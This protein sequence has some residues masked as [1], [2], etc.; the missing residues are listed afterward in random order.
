MAFAKTGLG[1]IYY[2]V[3]GEGTPVVLIRGLGCWSDHWG[4]WEQSLTE[5]YRVITLDGRGLGRS[6]VPIFPWDS[7]ST[8]AGDVLAVL[9]TEQ[10]PSAHI[11]GVSLGGMIA[12]QFGM[13]HPDRTKSITPIN[14][15]V[16]GSGHL[17]LTVS[18]FRLISS[19]HKKRSEFFDELSKLL[20]SPKSSKESLLK[21]SRDWRA[22]EER[23]P[24]PVRAVTCQL[25]LSLRWRPWQKFSNMNV[26]VHI[27]YGEDDRFVPKG[28]SLFIA[29]K[30]PQA[31]VTAMADSGHEP[32]IDQPEALTITLV[33][34][35]ESIG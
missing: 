33:R 32:H 22:I 1:N 12:L 23:Y 31:K 6:T 14:S 3:E 7:M 4:G 30:T 29:E 28:N 18:A 26:P 8:L 15:S 5:K 11:V 19:G 10:I 17:R 20:I 9:D 34:Y 35:F 2:Q 21:I 24:P 16:G 27:I 25:L 13:D